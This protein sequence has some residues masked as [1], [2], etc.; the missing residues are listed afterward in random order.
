MIASRL[1]LLRVEHPAGVTDLPSAGLLDGLG[2]AMICPA[3]AGTGGESDTGTAHAR[4]HDV[5][6]FTTSGRTQR[7]AAYPSSC[8][9]KTQRG[10]AHSPLSLA[11]RKICRKRALDNIPTG[12]YVMGT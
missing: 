8:A 3:Q 7:P 12:W 5:R 4:S 11:Q 10:T 1:T 6:Q 9:A 2:A